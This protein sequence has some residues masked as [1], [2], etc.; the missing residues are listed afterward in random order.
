MDSPQK[1]LKELSDLTRNLDVLAKE[2]RDMNKGNASVAKAVTQ[3]VETKKEDSKS[4]ATSAE[5]TTADAQKAQEGM[6]SKLLGSV[7]KSFEE[8]NEL[9]KSASLKTLDSAGKTL[10]ETGSLKEAAKSGIVEAK[11]SAKKAASQKA[12][13]AITSGIS[14]VTETPALK[15]KE[16]T[17]KENLTVDG[18]MNPSVKPAKT[19]EKENTFKI[20]SNQPKSKN[21]GLTEEKMINYANSLSKDERVYLVNGLASGKITKDDFERMINEKASSTSALATPDALKGKTPAALS[22]KIGTTAS[23]DE[24][25][26]KKSFK[27]VAK[28][29]FGKTRLGSTINS[30]SS[31]FKKKK[32]ASVAESGMKNETTTLKDQSKAKSEPAK[33]QAEVKKEVEARKETSPAVVQS[34]ESKK[35]ENKS[36]APTSAVSSS[37]DK[38]KQTQISAQDIQDIKGL[39]AA[40]NTTLN[41]PL[42]IKN[43]KPFRPTSSM[44]E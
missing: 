23:P 37:S 20:P 31:L 18:A 10:L 9:F 24:K 12:E 15:Q 19:G 11:D 6:F 34:S 22:P 29:E 43:N 35:E 21:P 40:I 33:P 4:A 3:S 30:I 8:G 14:K 25:P 42:A 41:G 2:V 7:K 32:E 27:E 5:K 39:L 16:K 17:P 28:E 13:Q 38:G 44:L 36:S 26:P 1:V